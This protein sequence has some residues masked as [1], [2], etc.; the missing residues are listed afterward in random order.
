MKKIKVSV[1]G[2]GHLGSIHVKL[3]DANPNA[4]LIGIRDIDRIKS[5]KISR[6]FNCKDYDSLEETFSGSDSLIIAVPTSIHYEIAMKAIEAGKHCL[7]EKPITENYHQALE[8]IKFAKEKKVLLQVGHVERFNPAIAAL[9]N[10]KIQPLFIESHRLAQFKPRARDVSVIHDLMIHDIDIVLWLVKSPIIGIDASGIKV[11]S[12]TI[13][14]ANARLKFKNGATANITASRISAHPMRKMRIFQEGA[15]LSLDF[16]EQTVDV[17]KIYNEGENSTEG[18]PATNLGSIETG[19]RNKNIYFEKPVVKPINAI[20][21]E[22][23][24]FLDA[25][26][27][28]SPIA[29]NA[30]EA[31]EALRVAEV[32]IEMIKTFAK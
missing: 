32:I 15:Y 7:I 14:I 1:I 19:L 12:D 4:V 25:I 30:E 22:Q 10:Y 16:Q 13:D 6:E 23:Q 20:A 21:E 28:K 5:Q 8:L 3:L 2:V 9:K 18:I 31:S 29:V 24:A 11:L 17:F 26:N 27:H